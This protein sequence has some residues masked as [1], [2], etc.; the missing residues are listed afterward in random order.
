MSGSNRVLVDLNEPAQRPVPGLFDIV[1]E[2]AG[3]QLP[4]PPM[5]GEAVAAD[6]LAAARIIAAVASGHVLLDVA[7]LHR[8]ASICFS[9]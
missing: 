2:E 8:V 1:G 9:F 3:G 7:F 6:A 5:I 4:V